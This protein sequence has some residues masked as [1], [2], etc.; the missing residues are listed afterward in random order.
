MSPL[1]KGERIWLMGWGVLLAV[2]L[3]YYLCSRMVVGIVQGVVK[4]ECLL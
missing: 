2:A 3:A 4:P 1:S